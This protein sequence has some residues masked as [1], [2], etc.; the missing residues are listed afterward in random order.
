MAVRARWLTRLPYPPDHASFDEGRTSHGWF[1]AMRPLSYKS[2]STSK[3][4]LTKRARAVSAPPRP[5]PDKPRIAP[6]KPIKKSLN[7][8]ASEGASLQTS[9]KPRTTSTLDRSAPD[10]RGSTPRNVKALARNSS[11]RPAQRD[12]RSTGPGT[13]AKT[14]H[15]FDKWTTSTG[16]VTHKAPKGPELLATEVGL[17]K[18]WSQA[19]QTILQHPEEAVP[20]MLCRARDEAV[21]PKSVALRPDAFYMA[22]SAKPEDLAYLK[23]M[24]T[25]AR[26]HGFQVRVLVEAE[27]ELF[28]KTNVS[29]SGLPISLIHV[30]ATAREVWTEDSGSF[31]GNT[32]SVAMPL[33]MTIEEVQQK[34]K[35]LEI[36]AAMRSLI[37][38]TSNE[39][40]TRGQRLTQLNELKPQRALLEESVGD[41]ALTDKLEQRASRMKHHIFHERFERYM[42]DPQEMSTDNRFYREISTQH[43][44]QQIHPLSF[45][46][47]GQVIVNNLGRSKIAVGMTEKWT[48]RADICHLE[49]GNVLTGLDTKRVPY[50]LVGW[51]SVAQSRYLL[52]VEGLASMG[53]LSPTDGEI[54]TLIRG[55]LG[56]DR[57]KQLVAA[58]LGLD[59]SRVLFIDEPA[60]FHLDLAM[61]ILSNN[62]IV[63]D[64]PDASAK[65]LIRKAKA[66]LGDPAALRARI[67]GPI[68]RE[69]ESLWR[70]R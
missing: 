20:Q 32:I 36:Q 69:L 61:G 28:I 23:T 21:V 51:D 44:G 38:V 50:A 31:G 68:I 17:R 9:S 57:M 4:A 29:L 65:I 41:Q 70:G 15:H 47:V 67:Q 5:S 64:D 18:A 59:H 25:V 22:C 33:L 42:G 46:P 26:A 8:E 39:N 2:S 55:R 62:L 19:V 43:L 58:D 27:N 63:I 13:A 34:A 40:L 66:L 52:A 60:D 7:Q 49:G 30:D 3:Q 1:R 24:A 53:N 48:L 11:E 16:I 12:T 54:R 35:L 14:R 10:S 37:D 45:D 6:D 56:D